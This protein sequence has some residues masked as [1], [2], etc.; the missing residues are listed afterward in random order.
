MYWREGRGYLLNPVEKSQWD[1]A[2]S[3]CS[4]KLQAIPPSPMKALLALA[5]IGSPSFAL[6]QNYHIRPY[7]NVGSAGV[8][9]GLKVGSDVSGTQGFSDSVHTGYATADLSTGELKT[10][11]QISN[12]NG[13]HALAL[14]EFSE[15]LTVYSAGDTTF[16]FS[17]YF[18][19]WIYGDAKSIPEGG[20]Y[21]I[22][23]VADFAVFRPGEAE[24]NTW[25][26]L[27]NA[28]EALFYEHH[29]FSFS[30][31]SEDF[32]EL[33]SAGSYFST[34]L[35]A[36]RE[37]FQIFARLQ[38]AVL[39]NTPQSATLDFSNTGTL[40]FLADPSVTVYSASGVFPDTLPIPEPSV[41]GLIGLA[42]VLG[43]RRRRH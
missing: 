18:D 12:T 22:I 29:S 32:D 5:L 14:S 17:F 8:I 40:S 7:V 24:W 42:A 38:H 20:A 16:E 31:P 41:A 28:G 37:D 1:L 35:G 2:F 21:Q 36:G 30:D 34:P 4:D 19:G 9:D 26:N 39:S 33:I 23:A 43:L 10:F 15:T 11:A 25:W 13:G 27:A 6:A 3:G